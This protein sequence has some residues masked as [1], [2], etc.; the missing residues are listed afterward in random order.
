LS[1]TLSGFGGR[2]ESAEQIATCGVEKVVAIALADRAQRVEKGAP[3]ARAGHHS[4]RTSV[5]TIR[6]VGA[7]EV[8]NCLGDALR[9]ER[10]QIAF[11]GSCRFEATAFV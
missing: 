7:V 11:L 4:G 6:P 3:R 5:A 9:H 2:S 8:G 1:T 10:W